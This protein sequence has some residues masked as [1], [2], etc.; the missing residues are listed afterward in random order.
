MMN[1]EDIIRDI[2]GIKI[3]KQRQP[4]F[5]Y[6]ECVLSFLSF[7]KI[8]CTEVIRFLVYYIL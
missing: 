2:I 4:H 7:F 5:S 3:Q 1:L 8:N 6:R